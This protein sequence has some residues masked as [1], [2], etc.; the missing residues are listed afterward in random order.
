VLINDK[1]INM[2]FVIIALIAFALYW[3]AMSGPFL[4]DDFFN[5]NSLQ[6]NGG[7]YGFQAWLDFVFS[8][9]SSFLG[10]PLALA[11]FTINA[12]TWPADPLP[13]KITNII[14]HCFNAWLVFYLLEKIKVLYNQTHDIKINRF[15]PIIGATI[16]L[17]HPIHLTTILQVIQR[18]TLL[19]GT[20]ILLSLIGYIYYLKKYKLTV[21]KSFVIL[22]TFLTIMGLFG[23]LSKET[24]IIVPLMMFAL[25]YTIFRKHLAQ[26]PKFTFIWQSLLLCGPLLLFLVG[27]VYLSSNLE[28]LWQARD[29]TLIERLLTEARILFQY[30]SHIFIPRASG[31]GLFHDDIVIST[32]FISPITTL[33][34]VIGLAVIIC[35]AIKIKKSAPFFSLAILWYLLGHIFESTVWPLELYFEHRNYIPSICLIFIL[36]QF[37]LFLTGNYQKTFLF[38][39][40]C[41]LTLTTLVTAMSTPLWGNEL[42]LFT[43]WAEENPTSIRAQHAAAMVWLNLNDDPISS[44]YFLLQAYKHNP[45]N[46]GTRIRLIENYCYFDKTDDNLQYF[47]RGLAEIKP[48]TVYLRAISSIIKLKEIGACKSLSNDFVIQFITV[49]ENNAKITSTAGSWLF[50]HKARMLLVSK[51]YQEALKYAEKASQLSPYLGTTLIKIESSIKLSNSILAK[52]YIQEALILE[53]TQIHLI[54]NYNIN[55]YKQFK[56]ELTKYFFIN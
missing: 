54:S 12:Q 2:S 5:L 36:F 27:S 50:Y 43:T 40:G 4:F 8:G 33:S 1:K 49:L 52:K 42:K 6:L 3:P 15:A 17:L 11:T 28:D 14:I 31:A 20:F 9:G 19:S 10:R 41:F 51:N 13:F 25:N 37:S 46:I 32:S 53:K 48:D 56:T 30:L 26:N 29:F 55:K 39:S 24:A 7:I 35:L 16:W 45:M 47:I 18:M 44:K 38:I 22:I 23:I 21:N 34:S